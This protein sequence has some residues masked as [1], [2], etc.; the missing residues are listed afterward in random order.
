MRNFFYIVFSLVCLSCGIVD[1]SSSDSI[2]INPSKYN[3]VVG[4][5]EEIY[6]KYG[7]SP[8][9]VSAQSAFEIQNVDG[10]VGGSFKW[11]EN[12]MVFTPKDSFEPAQ[13]Y[14]LKYAGEVSDTSGKMHKY[15]IYTPFFYMVKQAGKPD[16]T[17][18]NP[19][20][21]STVQTYDKV[22]FSFSAAMSLPSFLVGF[23]VSPDIDCSEEWNSE[24]TQMTL[25]PKEGW[26]EYQ[27]Y[28]FSFADSIKSADGIP[29]AAPK[30]FCLYCSSGAALPSVVSIDTALND[31][32]SYPLLLSGLDG[33]KDKDAIRVS[34]S[35]PMD[36]D[37][38]EDAFSITPDIA[39]HTCW[40]DASTLVFVPEIEWQG[41]TWY[42]VSIDTSAK[43]RKGLSITDKYETSF[44]PDV[45]PLKLLYVEGKDADGFPLSDF[46]PHHEVDIDVG[47]ALLPENTYT[48]G[49][50]FNK[51]FTTA[52]EKE[53][54]YS[55]IRLKG[56]F[57][58]SLTS[59]KVMSLFWSGDSRIQITY[60]GFEPEGRIYS[61]DVNGLEKITLRTR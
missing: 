8:D 9:H 16:I 25:T 12:T 1:F 44:T 30:T 33:V 26:K 35:E 59:P 7:F 45:I 61:L 46:N 23:S 14:V 27:V 34:F 39:G 36:L 60:I 29:I 49:F 3:Q 40:I 20:D 10:K 28:R 54:V 13:R 53:Q 15:N 52:E 51:A 57:P 22:V 6:V 5:N 55:G 41:E 48:F 42:S 43:S 19:A 32:L 18:M 37:A 58:P 2:K 38:A 11:K 24:H 31:G 56:L 4:E 50:V 21:G 17:R 47:D